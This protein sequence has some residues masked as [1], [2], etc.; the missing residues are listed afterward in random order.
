[1]A[2]RGEA[3]AVSTVLERGAA[4]ETLAGES[5]RYVARSREGEWLAAC[6]RPRLYIYDGARLG[7]DELARNTDRG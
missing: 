2:L 7:C 1:M 5:I 6:R 4:W 3:A